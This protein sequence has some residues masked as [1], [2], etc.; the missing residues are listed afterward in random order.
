MIFPNPQ[1]VVYRG[2]VSDLRVSAVDDTAF[3]DNLPAAIT[4]NYL[5]GTHLV[6]IYDSTGKAIAGVLGAQG[7]GETLG[8]ELLP[9][10]F[11]SGWSAV[12]GASVIDAG[13]FLGAAGADSGIRTSSGVTTLSGLLK[14]DVAGS[15]TGGTVSLRW[16]NQVTTPAIRVG[17]GAGY[18]TNLYAGQFVIAITSGGH[19]VTVT[20][21]TAKA[22][23]TPSTS[24]CTIVSAKGGATERFKR[25]DTGFAFN[26]SSYTVIIKKLS[27]LATARRGDIGVPG[28]LGFGVGVCP[29]ST[30]VTETYQ[31]TPLTGYQYPSSDNYGN[32]MTD[33]GSQV[34]CVPKFYYRMNHHENPTFLDQ[35]VA[36]SITGITQAADGV[37]TIASHGIPADVTNCKIRIVDVGGMTEVNDT[38]FDCAYVSAN[39][40][41]IG[42][43]TQGYTA[44]TSGGTA[45]IYMDDIDVKGVYDF[46]TTELANAAGYALHRA[47]IDGGVEKDFFFR[48]KYH[49]SSLAWG[50]GTVAASVKNG[51]P[52]ST[53][54]DHN[55]IANLTAC[56]V[57]QYYQALDACEAIDGV[58]GEV[59]GSSIWFCESIFISDAL[60]KLS[61]AHAQASFSTNN[62]GWY[63]STFNYPKGCNNNARRDTDDTTVLYTTDGYSN[64][65]KTGSGVVFNKT[66][67]NG[68]NCGIADLNG[69]M[70]RINIGIT[71]LASTK[72]ISAATQANPCVLTLNNITNLVLNSHIMITSVVGMTQLNDKMWKI[73]NINSGEG[74]VTIDVDSTGF[75]AYSSAGTL[76]YG[77]FYVA[78][79]ATAMKDFTSGTGA[80]A[81]EHWGSNGITAM[82]QEI[83]INFKTAAFAMICGNGNCNLF[84]GST[85][86]DNWLR[87]CLSIPKGDGLSSVGTNKFGKD[88]YY[89]YIRN[90][91][92][93]LCGGGWTGWYTAGVWGR[94]LFYPRSHSYTLVGFSS[95]C[96]L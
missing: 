96:Y 86:G 80:G 20:G 74:K 28:E 49:M 56:T 48:T 70:W 11:T 84:S 57:N 61:L 92:C 8:D 51:N 44:Y 59:N 17:F 5:G 58:N 64:A 62:C 38:D 18:V 39:S 13:S 53:A 85:S 78:K 2:T 26:S 25:I 71:C 36:V 29:L 37:M 7:S 79:Q 40:V 14:Y 21:K 15:T 19:T 89:Q 54:A 63:N 27:D 34:V 77:K 94:S 82:M 52:I 46:P 73:T 50:T 95:A 4:D 10:D 47:F 72:T 66:T 68:Q 32:Y 43:D 60:A 23:L 1:S 55:P 91:M 83:D 76:T 87:D 22:V 93:L 65:A 6:E 45:Y 69:N 30:G 90:L 24:G 31:I 88:Y 67:H 75:T 42:V 81:T 33:S 12:N 41:T 35:A 3:L 16:S 9:A